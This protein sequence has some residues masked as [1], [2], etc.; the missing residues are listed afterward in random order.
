MNDEL[1]RARIY[2]T[3][4]NYESSKPILRFRGCTNLL[5][6]TSLH[7]QIKEMRMVLYGCE[8]WSLNIREDHILRVL[9]N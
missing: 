2:L 1:G 5:G 7:N 8:T 4:E 6:S 3:E 9:G